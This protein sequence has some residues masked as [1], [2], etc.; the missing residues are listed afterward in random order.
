MGWMKLGPGPHAYGAEADSVWRW[1]RGQSLRMLSTMRFAMA[2]Q[3]FR[4]AVLGWFVGLAG[5]ATGISGQVWAQSCTTQSKMSAAQ[6]DE[7]GAAAYRLAGA[8]QSGNGDAV[9]SQTIAQFAS[10]FAATAYLVR[11]TSAELAGDSLRVAQAYLLDASHRAANDASDAEFSCPLGGSAAETD[12]SIGGLPA[13]RYAFVMVEASGPHP[14]VLSFLLQQE[15]GGWKM[16]GFYPHHRSVAGH[17]GVWYWT[18]A[19]ADAKDGKEWLAW[20]M[21]GEADELLRPAN[22]VTST[23]LDRLRSELRSVTPPQLADGISDKMPLLLQGANGQ[24]FRITS[25]ASEGSEDGRQLNLVMHL[26]AETTAD[27]NAATTRNLAAAAALLTAHPEL[28]SG[29][30]NVW[31]IA[32][33]AGSNP[34]VTEKPMAEMA[35]AK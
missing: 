21:Y 6:R 29:F 4:W 22:F 8:V 17:D 2:G 3:R 7:I 20:V 24:S 26:G 27:S 28:R 31:V 34:F 1:T 30:D 16:A 5:A 33:T 9:R 25:L 10:D 19:R 18:T 12:F 11:T 23:N 35:Q 14:W 13:G 15:G 32:D